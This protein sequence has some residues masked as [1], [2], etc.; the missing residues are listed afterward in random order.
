MAIRGLVQ[1]VLDELDTQRVGFIILMELQFSD[2]TVRV[3]GG[4]FGAV[5]DYD[6]SMWT[7]TGDYGS[8]DRVGE[9]EDV[10]DSRMRATIRMSSANIT[11]IEMEDNEG[12][13]AILRIVLYDL[14]TEALIGDIS[15]TREMGASWV[16]PRLIEEEGR[17]ITMLDLTMEFV[18][19]GTI[20]RRRHTRRLTHE[21]TL[22]MD[23]ADHFNEFSS[24]PDLGRAQD[25][26]L[27]RLR[28]RERARQERRDDR[29]ND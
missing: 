20:L 10:V 25:E 29:R 19:E 21:D 4:P 13:K 15:D 24:D 7:G 17:K 28:E 23:P 16:E 1:A 12:R 5:L 8:I 6:G 26:L 2:G 22:E 14:D 9:A 27:M 11:S 18:G 3:W